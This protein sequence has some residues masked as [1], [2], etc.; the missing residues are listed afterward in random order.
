VWASPRLRLAPQRE[1]RLRAVIDTACV[2]I[3][4]IDA[5]GIIETCNPA[6]ERLFGYRSSEMLGQPV[7]MLMPSPYREEHHSYLQHYLT[8]RQPKIIGLGREVL[9]RRKDG[10]LFPMSLSVGEMRLEDRVRFTGIIEDITARKHAEAALCQTAQ[11]LARSNTDLEQF[12]YAASHDLQEPVRAVVGCL[13]WRHD[14]GDLRSWPGLNLYFY[15]PRPC[16]STPQERQG[17]S[18]WGANQV[19]RRC[20]PYGFRCSS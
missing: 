2:G 4:T 1:T 16:V 7:T 19:A 8:T 13:Q 14:C 9:G 18:N 17:C 20:C 5:Q 10:S 15:H 11:E 12:A 3:L 6:S